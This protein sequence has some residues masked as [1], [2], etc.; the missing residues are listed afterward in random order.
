M[1]PFERPALKRA[2]EFFS[3]LNILRME[4]AFGV[5]GLGITFWMIY[6]LGPSRVAANLHQI[7]WGF[8]A[9]TAM[10]GAEYFLETIA[11]MLILAGEKE[12]IGFW[13]VFKNILE[14]NALNYIT[15][16]RMGGEPLK[17]VAF[18]DR[19]GLAKS[20]ASAI[21]LKYCVLMGF[22]IAIS[23]GFIV[24]LFEADI[25]AD[26]KI[27]IG[28]GIALVSLFMLSI[29]WIQRIGVFSPISW[30][31]KK[32]ESQRDWIKE[33]ILRLTHMDKQIVETYRSRP[34]G[35][36]IAIFLC[37][38]GWVEE[39][40]F[41]WLGLEFL[42]MGENWLTA[43]SIGTISMLLNHLLFFVPWRAGTQEGTVV[44]AFTIT[45]L[46]EPV[47]L[48]IAILKRLRELVWVFVGLSFFA[49]ETLK[50]PPS[51]LP[52]AGKT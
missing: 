12:K 1:N 3:A 33:N 43:I 15:M 18:K 16:T 34:L 29:S 7:G 26:F 47:G 38:L 6:R 36:T 27:K 48:S 5:F 31:L 20:A 10:K 23:G 9:L 8:F 14:G 49:S 17:A 22:W 51:A 50:S 46:S 2:R 32:F 41:I 19:L 25:P 4:R 28:G 13:K 24:I 45:D 35:I 30:V 44:L 52:Q 42:R 37:T 21:V 39:I 11:W 40:V